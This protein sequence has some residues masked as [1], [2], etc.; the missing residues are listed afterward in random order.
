[1][2]LPGGASP[3]VAGAIAL[4]CLQALDQYIRRAPYQ[5]APA[6]C[7]GPAPASWEPV[8][9]ALAVCEARVSELAICPASPV[10]VPEPP[11]EDLPYQNI[12][13]SLGG[14]IAGAICLK[15]VQLLGACLG[16]RPAAESEER[17][18]EYHAAEV[19]G[20]FASDGR[21]R[22]RRGLAGIMA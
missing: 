16:R 10:P 12:F 2:P 15:L 18:D 14:S 6:H 17:L 13:L 8:A 22:R 19:D 9:Q 3:S 11:R 1:M 5:E 20:R 7:T 4:V 21:R